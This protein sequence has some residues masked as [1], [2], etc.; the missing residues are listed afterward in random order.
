MK[1][2]SFLMQISLFEGRLRENEAKGI[3]EIV[4]G[5]PLAD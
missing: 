3:S 1:K 2:N 4:L 5:T